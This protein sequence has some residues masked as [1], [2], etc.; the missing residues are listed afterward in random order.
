MRNL[1][2]DSG[3]SLAGQRIENP[4][5]FLADVADKCRYEFFSLMNITSPETSLEEAILC[6]NW[7]EEI[8]NK[9]GTIPVKKISGFLSTLDECLYPYDWFPEQ[10]LTDTEKKPVPDFFEI[11]TRRNLMNGVVVPVHGMENGRGA[12]I[13]GNRINS[14]TE[15]EFCYLH[16]SSIKVF[17]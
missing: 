2:S 13:F 8:L 1:H 9:F 11:L 6:S 4:R 17:E 5:D 10:G 3:R 14:L 15:T 12:V 16:S 7:P